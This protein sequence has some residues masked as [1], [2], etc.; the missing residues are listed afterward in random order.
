MHLRKRIQSQ[1][2]LSVQQLSRYRGASPVQLALSLG[3]L[4]T[5]GLSLSKASR[6]VEQLRK[7][8][9]AEKS[10][11]GYPVWGGHL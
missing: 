10:T 9:A 8:F 2:P 3:G 11:G 6:L 5:A 7:K 1:D 4:G